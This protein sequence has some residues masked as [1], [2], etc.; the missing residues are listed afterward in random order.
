[1]S[2]AGADYDVA[3]H[4]APRMSARNVLDIHAGLHRMFARISPLHRAMFI[5]YALEDLRAGNPEWVASHLHPATSSADL[6]PWL[7]SLAFDLFGATTFQV[8]AEMIDLARNLSVTTPDLA[9]LVPEDLPEDSGFMW[10]DEPVER[11]SV[12]DKP[13][14]AVM[15]MQ[16]VSWATIPQ[17][18]VRIGEGG[19]IARVPA[20]RI[21][22]WGWNDTPNSE[23][24]P[25]HLMGQSTNPLTRNVHTPL[26]ELHLVHMIWI[27]MGMEIVSTEPVRA[28][29]AAMR[30]AP[31]LRHHDVR[32]VKLRRTRPRPDADRPVVH[33]E[34]D[35]TCTWLVRAHHRHAHRQD[36]RAVGPYKRSGPCEVCG[37]ATSFIGAYIKGPD[38]LPLKSADL[39]VKLAR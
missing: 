27:L 29:R 34:I 18:E 28:D 19:P 6:D 2:F 33:R 32:V 31:N 11:P 4:T 5:E 38:G 30:R 25:L 13:G 23:P 7:D 15:V 1:M 20:V 14:M 8:T 9:D 26:T 3:E 35:W 16:A 37:D 21:R 22:E 39:L 10:L 24:R 12:E 36:H 17:M